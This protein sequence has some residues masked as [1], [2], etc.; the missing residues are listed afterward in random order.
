LPLDLLFLFLLLLLLLLLLFSVF[1]VWP[2]MCPGRYDDR[3]GYDDRRGSGGGG[4][5]GG[6]GGYRGG[7]M[8]KV[9]RRPID[10]EGSSQLFIGNL[11]YDI[12]ERE[13][14]DVFSKFGKVVVTLIRSRED[15]QCRHV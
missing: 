7:G 6:G 10:T 13:L 15:N 5:G 8:E 1:L 4:G 12:D 11:P 14:E 9:G 2:T 3:G